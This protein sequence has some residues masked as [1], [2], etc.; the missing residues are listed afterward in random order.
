[1]TNT[2]IY[3]HGFLGFK[4]EL[5]FLTHNGPTNI[6]IVGLNWQE[7]IDLAHDYTLSDIAK[8]VCGTIRKLGYARVGIFGYSMG[9]RL[10]MQCACVDPDLVTSL[11]LE[12]AHFGYKTIAQKDSVY[13]DFLNRFNNLNTLT[14]TKF[15]DSWY[16][17]DLFCLTKLCL[18]PEDFNKK[19]SLNFVFQ[20]ELMIRLHVSKQPYFIDL[21]NDLNIPIFYLTGSKD[22]KYSQYAKECLKTLK[23]FK[24]TIIE[25]ADHN[26]HISNSVLF[27]K[28]F[29]YHIT[30]F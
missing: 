25:D 29:F 13:Q 7:C 19:E 16:N 23:Q 11:Y 14:Q 3:L 2:L 21:L 22:S 28:W 6:S 5:D 1:M 30:S 4:D 18:S 20:K 12:S 10:A 9:G 27:K 24:L 8:K 17:Q 15:L 26:V